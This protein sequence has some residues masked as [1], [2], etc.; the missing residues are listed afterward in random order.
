M[1][2]QGIPFA[3]LLTMLGGAVQAQSNPAEK[4]LLD[5]ANYWYAQNRPQDAEQ[6]VDR[7]LR[8]DPDN[9][10]GLALLAQLQSQLGDR[11]KAQATLAHL[12]AVRPND[13]QI[14]T[15]EQAIR[16]GSLDPAGLAE[17]RRLAQEGHNAEAVARYQCLF[18]GAAP[19]ATLAV[20]YYDTLSGTEGGWDAARAGLAQVVAASPRDLRAQLAYA[21]L[22]TYRDQ[23]RTEGAQ[24]LAVLVH[25]PE[26]ATAAAKAWRQALE[27][28]PV[29]ASSIQ[30]YEAW[31]AD[32]PNDADI[33]GR[34]EQARNPP[35]APIDEAALKRSAGFAALDAGRI[36]EA[37]TDFQTVLGQTPQDPDA[38]GGLGLVRLRQ[39]NAAEART[40]L[41]RA[42]AADPTHKARWEGALQGASVGED[43]AA[44]R[45]MI[46]RGQLDA[47][48]RQLRAIISSGGDVTGAQLMLADV[49]SRRGD[50]A[51]A[52]TQYRAALARQPNNADA[53][54]G[55]AQVLNRQGRG[56]EA[57]AMLD[58]A[59]SAGNS[60]AVGRIRAD[61]LR[62]QAAA[63]TDPGAK[64]ALLRAAVNADPGDPWT[65]LDLAR[66]LLATGKKAEARQVMAEV[67]AGANPSVDALRAGAMFAA[68][69][70]RPADAAVLA[71]RLPAAS[72]TADMR[73]LLAQAKRQNDIRSA[74]GLAALSPIA[75]REKLLMLAAQ[76]DPDGTNGVAVARAFLQMDNPAGAREALA[77][78]QA[79]TRTPTPAQRIAYAG[80]LLQA[81]DERGANI[82][83]QALTETSGLTPEQ[84]NAL[85]RLRAGS[86]IRKADTLNGQHQQAAA[87]DVLA[88]A[89]ERQPDNPELNLAVARLYAAADQP[90]KALAINQAVL[91]RDPSDLDARKAALDVAIQASDWAR[92]N[93]LVRDGIAAAPDNPRIWMMSA[94]LDRARGDLAR[95]YD[96]LKR[97]QALRRQ[98]IGSDDQP[99]FS[100]PG[101][102]A[103]PYATDQPANDGTT[104]ISP[105]GNPFRHG[106]AEES[107]ASGTSAFALTTT[108]SS[109][110][111]LQDIDRQ[112]AAAQQDLAPK[113]TIGPSFRSR[114]GTSGLDQLDE[115]SL[116]TELVA[117][118]LGRG[119][120]TVT[121]APTF[122]SSGNVP[123]DTN[124]QA[125]FGTGAFGLHPA[126]PS[127]DANGVGLSLAYQLGW[128]EADVGTSP[129]GFQQQNLLGG[130]ELSPLI[131]DGVRLR[132]VGERRAVTDS[133]L[134][135]AGTR[136]P[137]TGIA[138]GGV[139]RTRGHAQLELSVGEANVYAGGGYAVLD[140]E[141]VSS[142][143]EY[144]F[145]T[146]GSYPVWR[147][148]QNDEVRLGMDVIYFG[149]QKNL[150]F[151]TLG[152][153][154]YFSPQSYFATLLP[155]KYTA[156][157]NDLTWSIGGS[158]G[159]QTYN[160]HASL[161][162]PNNPVF[163]NALVA[164]AAAVTTPLA[165][166]FPGQTASG[167]V[168]GAQGSVEYRVNDV[169]VLGAQAS[170]QHA[171]NWSETIARLYG[172][173]VF[174]GGTW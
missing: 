79:A 25:A 17:A 161:V 140:G 94:T 18:Q 151:F 125:R 22:L 122:L 74:V 150:D 58:R 45:T 59:Q 70:G 171:G 60:R 27:W 81:G 162:F 146:G 21:Q 44:A 119:Q 127:Q 129:I 30:A 13:P 3:A 65:R 115:I 83:V 31:L 46:Q 145:G 34:L 88:P 4:V 131:A 128:A 137:A 55:M 29:D 121:A 69:D 142:N 120:I 141:N 117:R 76:P 80:L 173:Y 158:L 56:T 100:Q 57:E 71:N 163:Q 33:S 72:R 78:A 154:G 66:S 156:K 124:S 102:A 95:A 85:N 75:A 36:Q 104:L 108:S 6:A 135:Y 7:L 134:S 111:L 92:A 165:T 48:E 105:S 97:A 82:L 89:L 116:P 23:T 41:S 106:E 20:E 160:E 174:G 26:T 166:S 8:V 54:V 39:G 68:E 51:G 37:E 61:A 99:P 136:D 2:R 98:E 43:Y 16:A 139:T 172:R 148:S 40:L 49:L 123:L 153:G 168:G 38:L 9:P 42:I 93:A 67:T 64:E 53:L 91:E 143:W 164:E 109:D 14:A 167:V 107:P 1:M 149:Y 19:P 73:A 101:V 11:S 112:M 77:T 118:P 126:P 24:R 47:A 84:T 96:D 169:F 87:Y 15:V 28:M 132:I 86:A 35:R 155:V 144:E 5:Q 133:V 12:R 32:H 170:Y 147:G 130:I 157:T 63:V 159:Y 50:L 10:D 114:T 113:I 103:H 152:Q 52:E 110:P 90:R 138:W 62:Q